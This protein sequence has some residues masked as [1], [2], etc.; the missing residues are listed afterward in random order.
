MS[1]MPKD[2]K[3]IK[4]MMEEH[5]G[6]EILVTVQLGRRRQKERRG[7][8]CETYHSVFVVNLDQEENNFERVSYSYRDVLTDSIE[9]EFV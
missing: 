2:L 8:L 6:K 5:V 9:V 3:E 7:I 1:K 4:N